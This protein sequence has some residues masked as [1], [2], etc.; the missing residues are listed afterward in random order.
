MV[1]TVVT[2]ALAVLAGNVVPGMIEEEGLAEIVLA[3]I[4]SD[5]TKLGDK[6][7]V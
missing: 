6:V 4:T 5:G 7:V 3:G 1:V 2:T